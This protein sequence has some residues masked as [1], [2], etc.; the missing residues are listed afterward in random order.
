MN[1]GAT[2]IS[3]AR[4]PG[5]SRRTDT[6]RKPNALPL[7]FSVH[8]VLI[9]LS[10]LVWWIA[11]GQVTETQRL[12][13]YSR[14]RFELAEELRGQWRIVPPGDR[15]GRVGDSSIPIT[16]EVSGPARRLND[17][18]NELRENPGRYMY[19]CRITASDLPAEAATARRAITLEIRREDI[20]VSDDSKPPAELNVVAITG[21]KLMV[22]LEPY[23]TRPAVV[24]LGPNSNIVGMV[25]GYTHKV[26]IVP[27][28]VL[29]VRG[30]LS[31][32][33]QLGGTASE[34]KLAL[35]R[36]DIG[37]TINIRKANE[38]KTIEQLLSQEA[39]INVSAALAVRD[40]ITVQ[41]VTSASGAEPEPEPVTHVNLQ[42]HFTKDQESTKLQQPFPVEV[43][44]PAWLQD[45]S[46]RPTGGIQKELRVELWVAKAQQ[47]RFNEDN[48][49]VIVDLGTLKEEDFEFSPP[50]DQLNEQNRTTVAVLKQPEWWYSLWISYDRLTARHVREG[51]TDQQY[52]KITGLTL[53]C[54]VKK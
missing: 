31:R 9:V 16:V 3:G 13:D 37:E 34:A 43:L 42:F 49:R 40:D 29:Q 25:P 23:V 51:L 18:A 28:T 53:E 4:A 11:R 8:I 12:E 26:S 50:L 19:V 6:I 14:L 32:V 46:V 1:S 38:N 20:R 10:I 35:Q 27:G 7:G 30:P 47:D 41:Q 52:E 33:E 54:T 17:F 15:T 21:E 22:E 45:Y 5:V 24:D 44:L 48:V 39:K 2:T 36:L